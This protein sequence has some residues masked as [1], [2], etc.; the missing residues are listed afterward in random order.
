MNEMVKEISY[1][2]SEIDTVIKE[3]MACMARCNIFAF[4]GSLGA[5][6]TTIIS[7][8]LRASGVTMPITSP[9]FT[10]V[11]H[12]ENSAGEQ[13][14]HFDLYRI[15]DVEDFVAQ[16]FDEYLHQENTWVFIEWP[17]VI[18]PLLEKQGVC[19]VHCDYGDEIDQRLVTIKIL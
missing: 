18:K 17:E 3:I 1:S 14:Y 16:G 12:Y 10:Y 13:F 4:V 11:N 8:V 19:W 9:T 15:H 6:K 5:G 7:Q 2:F